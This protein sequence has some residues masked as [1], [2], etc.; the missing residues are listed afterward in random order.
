MRVRALLYH[1]IVESDPDASGFAGP[2]AAR[3]KLTVAQLDEHL[4]ALRAAVIPACIT[5]RELTGA[6]GVG[7]L[8]TMDDGGVSAMHL[9][10]RIERLGWRA[11]F[12]VTTARIGS[13][14]FLTRAQIRE[15]HGR[16]HVIGA[17][18]HTHP[19]RISKLPTPELDLEWRRST[20]ILRDIVAGP[21]DT[22]SVP[23]GFF[24]PRVAEAAARSGVS[25]LFTSEPTTRL[26]E[27]HG[28][29]IVGRYTIYGGMS[30][31]AAADLA[32][33]SRLALVRQAVQWNGKKA[34][35]TVA[36]P[37]WEAMRRVVFRQG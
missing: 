25:T 35:K 37:V 7:L 32:Q 8:L 20:D 9:A 3:Y 4:D 31:A 26:A 13:Q 24:A 23:G 30:A 14:G 18:S 27:A 19:Y 12:F 22:A 17:H 15:L 10:E 36:A 28:C 6:D 1:D 21:I 29:L 33:G 11:H 5:A 34:V 2:A 16:G